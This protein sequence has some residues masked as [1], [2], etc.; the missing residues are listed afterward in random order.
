MKNI[1]A[2]IILLFSSH[3]GFAQQK[4]PAYDSVN[5][6]ITDLRVQLE[7]SEAIDQL[8]NFKFEEAESIFRYIKRTYPKHPIGYFLLGLSNWWRIAPN[9]SNKKY[10]KKFTAYMDSCIYFAEEI[11]DDYKGD[12]RIEAAFFLT[13]AY[14]ILGRLEAERGNWTTAAWNGK[15]ALKFMEIAH[16]NGDLSPEIFFG[17]GLYNYYS[18][19]IPENHKYLKPVLWFFKKGD[20]ATGI[21]QLEKVVKNGFYTRV[22]AQFFLMIINEDEK[23]QDKALFYAE[24]LNK[25]FPDNALFHRYYLRMLYLNNS[26]SVLYKEC[27]EVLRRMDAEQVGYEENTARYAAFY[28]GFIAKYYLRD[29]ANAKLYLEKSLK[30]AEKIDAMEMGYTIYA[31]TYLAEIYDAEKNILRAKYYYEQVIEYAEK[32]HPSYKVAKDYLKKHKKVK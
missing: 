12:K 26:M 5:M 6:L 10:D 19:W 21:A 17:D 16:G 14:G 1:I 11:Y 20:K 18:I 13:T 23:K 25:Q 27:I 31:F 8:Y 7:C 3:F 24:Y 29:N 9:V 28:G 15:K 4:L 32:K 22:E 2:L 30:Y